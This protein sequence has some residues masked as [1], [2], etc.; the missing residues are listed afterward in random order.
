MV[1]VNADLERWLHKRWLKRH[2]PVM[3]CA[4]NTHG[5]CYASLV[6]SVDGVP[7]GLATTGVTCAQALEELLGKPAVW[8][9]IER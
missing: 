8:E 2:A 4:V 1:A 6:W 7:Y 9:G 5:R 3:Q